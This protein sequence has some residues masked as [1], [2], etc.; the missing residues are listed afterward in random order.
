MPPLDPRCPLVN[1][2]SLHI[3]TTYVCGILGLGEN[4]V[5]EVKEDNIQLK[6]LTSGGKYSVSKY[7]EAST[8]QIYKIV[9]CMRGWTTIYPTLSV[10]YACIVLKLAHTVDNQNF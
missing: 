9:S 6:T 1:K 3:Y 5:V 10:F 7:T 8:V 2:M 4:R